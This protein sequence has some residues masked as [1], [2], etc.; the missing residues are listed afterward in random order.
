MHT[1][2]YLAAAL[3]VAVC[4]AHSWL[5]ERY[6]LRRLLRRPD[7]PPLMGSVEL[8]RRTLRVGW[9]IASLAWLGLAAVLVAL[10]QPGAS[11]GTVSVVVGA[12]F[13]A[14]FLVALLASRGKHLSWIC[15]LCIALLCV[16]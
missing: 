12:T 7:L 11:L 15:F 14:H 8:M 3:I 13:F 6:L 4:V 9:H 2:V 16:W 1:T 10:V 5:G